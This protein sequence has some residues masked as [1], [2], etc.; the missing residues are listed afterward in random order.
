MKNLKL[1]VKIS[2]IAIGIL[3]IGLMGLWL[4]TDL[5]M[6]KIMR[7]AIIQQLSDSVMT[8]AEIVR[9]YVDKA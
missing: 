1:A 8:Q 7:G 4:G 2:M 3:V 5:Q 9:N 6:T